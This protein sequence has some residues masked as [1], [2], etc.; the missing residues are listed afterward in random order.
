MIEKPWGLE[1]ILY[2]DHHFVTKRITINYGQ[3]TSLQ[4]HKEKTECLV[5]ESGVLELDLEEGNISTSIMF[6]THRLY[7]GQ[8]VTIAPKQVH[9]LKSYGG[10]VVLIETSTN[11]LDDVVRLEDDYGRAN[12]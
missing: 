12:S 3:R 4:Y 8:T 10:P 6:Q 7:R 5:V 9:R 2:Q 1:E 11:H